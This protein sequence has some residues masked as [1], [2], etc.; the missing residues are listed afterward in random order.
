MKRRNLLIGTGAVAAAAAGGV[1]LWRPEDR[2]AP[3]NAYF[4]AL[5]EMLKAESRILNAR[6]QKLEIL[7]EENTRLRNLLASSR[8]I[9]LA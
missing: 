8:K 9:A 7:A 2:G 3:H 6:L 1:L 4:N 5:N